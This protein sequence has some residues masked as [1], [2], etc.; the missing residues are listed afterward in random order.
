[1]FI[2]NEFY[3]NIE[4]PQHFRE[5]YQS[6]AVFGLGGSSMAL[7]GRVGGGIYSSAI[8]SN[9]YISNIKSEEAKSEN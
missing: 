4:D 7:F 2:Y 5:M 1:M 8:D 3:A 6:I 9:D